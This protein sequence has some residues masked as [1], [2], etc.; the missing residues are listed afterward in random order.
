MSNLAI[1][2]AKPEHTVPGGRLVFTGIGFEPARA[3]AIRVFFGDRRA[4][5][6]RVSDETISV[7]VP[8]TN[9]LALARVEL[10]GSSSEPY[11]TSVARLVADDLHPVANPAF[12]RTGNLFVTFSGSR[13]QKVPFS[14]YQISLDGQAE[15]YLSDIANPTGMALGKD[16]LL[17]VSSRHEGTVYRIG[18][19]RSI[20]LV[21]DEL[22]VATGLAFDQEGVLHVGDRQGTIYRIEPNG[23]PRS[24]CQLPPSVAAYHLAFD[25]RGM[26]FV[27]GPSLSSVDSIYRI[28]QDAKV[29]VFSSGLGRPQGMAFDDDGNLYVAEALAGDSGV[30]RYSPSGDRDVFIS[31]PPLVGLAFDGKG[32]VALADS[33][34]VFH[35]DVGVSGRSLVWT[36]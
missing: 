2:E 9:G 27:S 13:G 14:L 36:R 12:D 33:S 21:A 15:P 31:S 10:D 16:G 29:E 30:Y 34:A 32:G 6:T 26:L 28:T 23:E 7:I 19:D 17:Y 18:P 8:Q 24:F 20:E 3:H 35:L 22:G 1:T 25:D 11:P 5:I 4:Q